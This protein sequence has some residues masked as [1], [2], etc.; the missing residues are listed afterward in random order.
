MNQPSDDDIDL[1]ASRE[2][3]LDRNSSLLR[4]ATILLDMLENEQVERLQ[5]V[6]EQWRDQWHKF[7]GEVQVPGT[8][9]D[10]LQHLRGIIDRC[11]SLPRSLRDDLNGL[12]AVVGNSRFTVSLGLLVNFVMESSAND[13][14]VVLFILGLLLDLLEHKVRKDI[15]T[16]RS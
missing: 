3:L 11:V 12:V 14:K 6:I 9:P 1:E 16:P 5:D 2:P 8:I 4:R 7:S 15:V 10:S 13:A